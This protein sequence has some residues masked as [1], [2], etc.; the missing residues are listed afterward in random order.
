MLAIKVAQPVLPG[1]MHHM[2]IGPND[3]AWIKAVR[4]L[5]QDQQFYVSAFWERSPEAEEGSVSQLANLRGLA[6]HVSVHVLRGLLTRIV[7]RMQ[8]FPLPAVT[9]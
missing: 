2:F 8:H 5:G 4:E 3:A 7:S 9:I 1:L 6:C